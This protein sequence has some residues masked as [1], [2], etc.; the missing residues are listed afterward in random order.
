VTGRVLMHLAN[1]YVHPY[2]AFRSSYSQC[3]IPG[4]LEDLQAL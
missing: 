3:H 2:R 4:A 1:D